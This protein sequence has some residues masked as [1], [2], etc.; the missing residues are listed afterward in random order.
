MSEDNNII[1]NE[2]NNIIVIKHNNINNDDNDNNN[3][4]NNNNDNNNDDDDYKINEINN[5]FKNIDETKSFKEQINLLKGTDNLCRYWY[6]KYYYD[7][8]LNLN[9]FKLKYAYILEDLGE[10]LFEEIFDH[11]FVTLA[12]KLINTTSEEENQ[13]LINDIKKNEDKIY[14]RERFK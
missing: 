9:I 13:M 7:K 12:N 4:D 14:E 5:I 1:V 10:N 6:M 3:N 2:N 8:E 11:T